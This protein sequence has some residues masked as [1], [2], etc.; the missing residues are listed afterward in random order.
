MP[1]KLIQVFSRESINL[2][3]SD[4]SA[5]KVRKFYSHCAGQSVLAGTPVGSGQDFVSFITCTPLLTA[6]TAFGLRRRRYNYPQCCYLHCLRTINSWIPNTVSV[7]PLSCCRMPYFQLTVFHIFVH[8]C[9]QN[10]NVNK[11][12]S[13]KIVKIYSSL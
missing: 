5:R 10:K 13:I 1:A 6:S 7:I 11:C 12:H 2:Q 4:L 3:N 8:L 9:G